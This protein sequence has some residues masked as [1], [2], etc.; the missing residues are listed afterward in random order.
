MALL[1]TRD[2]YGWV[3]ILNHWT[4]AALILGLTVFGLVLEEMPRGPDK[5]ALIDIHKT[6]GVLALALA[7]ARIGWSALQ[8]HPA[9]MADASPKAVRARTIM[10]GL[11]IA[12]TLALPISGILMSLYHD[13]AVSLLGL[14]TIPAQGT[15]AWIAEPAGVVHALGGKL[16][17]LLVA[18]HA[19]VSL[20][21]HLWDRDPT[22]RRM[23]G[24]AGG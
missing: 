6:L 9:A 23:L 2:R 13:H 5:G 8:P 12:A 16:V 21:H 20:K 15:V 14:A 7:L 18:G 17:L 1:N 3:S 10:H 22:L 4:I 11:L 19:V 24:T